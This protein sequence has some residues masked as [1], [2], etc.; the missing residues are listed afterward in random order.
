VVLKLKDKEAIVADLRQVAE[1][2]LSVIAAD[3]RG[4]TVSEMDELRSEARRSGVYVR[5]V[6]NTLSR[7]ALQGTEFNCI[8]EV[9]EGPVVLAFSRNEPGAAARILKNFIVNHE[10]FAVKAIALGG[11]LFA[12]NEL[13]TIAKLPTCDEAIAILMGVMQAPIV[14]LARTL[15]EI[16]GKLVRTVAAVAAARES[17][18]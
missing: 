10:K 6:R 2:S 16:N 18:A 3:Y 13:D 15:N 8:Q 7:R 5:V 12:A 1:S 4:L 14:K 9:L 17:Q 11:E